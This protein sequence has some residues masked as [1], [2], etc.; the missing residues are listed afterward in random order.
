MDVE[1]KNYMED[2][3][4]D[5]LP[6][7]LDK[8]D[9][10]KCPRCQMDIL[11]YSLNNLPPKYVVTRKGDIYTRLAT[12]HTQFSADIIAAVTSGATIVGSK[13]RHD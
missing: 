1:L 11:A 4:Q 7:V 8:M 13:P 9:I 6:A 3:V 12:M 10:C 2:L 5:M